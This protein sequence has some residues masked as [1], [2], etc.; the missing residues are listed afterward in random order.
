[1][2]ANKRLR[3]IGI[4]MVTAQ[5]LIAVVV[6]QWLTMQ[7]KEEHKLL[8]DNISR[9]WDAAN[10]QM[11]DSMLM[12]H[13]INPAIDSTQKKFT[14][15]FNH[16]SSAPSP[17]KGR[18]I[19][20]NV[21]DSNKHI[22]IINKDRPVL[23]KEDSL[24]VN[25]EDIIVN[26]LVLRGVKLFVNVQHDSLGMKQSMGLPDTSM[27]KQALRTQLHEVDPHITVT[28]KTDSII[29]DDDSLAGTGLMHDEDQYS[30]SIM[31]NDNNLHAEINGFNRVIAA[32]LLPWGLFGLLLV[33]LSAAA[34]L[35]SYR[36]LRSQ[37]LLNIQRNDFIR[38]MSHELRTPVA[39]VKVA[40]EAINNFNTESDRQMTSEYL[41]MAIMETN[42]LEMLINR[43]TDLMSE[44][45]LRLVTK[46][47]DLS[48]L[49]KE[50]ASLMKPRLGNEMASLT[51]TGVDEP[52]LVT[53]DNLH[54][55]G[56][57]I[58]LID[59]SL[60]YSEPPAYIEVNLSR[61]AGMVIITVT[62]R[63]TGIPAEYAG[64]IFEKFFRVPQGDTHNIKGYGLGLAY[65]EAVI[66]QHGGFISYHPRS[67]GGSIF[68]IRLKSF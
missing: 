24:T 38:N 67:G 21:S 18:R 34:F 41:S 50:V 16:F 60:K 15:R 23:N 58:N 10:Q 59:N 8:S 9:A 48:G 36:S 4:M 61:D 66:K 44:G 22:S 13:Y 52:V 68:E 64:R 20:V 35:V 40:L 32:N 3:I 2:K 1:M 17:Q 29:N 42:R 43:V 27:L 25:T 6:V 39:T 5:V 37:M 47:E 62:D 56:V 63:G 7:Y 46:R 14:F 12:K 53:I 51:L 31:L 45:N 57:L 49:L 19:F 26:D 65:A 11:I 55:K 30:Y 33:L 28:W 54:F